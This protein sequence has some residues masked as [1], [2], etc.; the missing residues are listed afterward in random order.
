MRLGVT[1]Q[2][3]HKI[4]AFSRGR[5]LVEPS[6]S[7]SLLPMT[8]VNKA[9]TCND[10]NTHKPVKSSRK[11]TT[12]DACEEACVPKVA[13]DSI[14]LEMTS[15][16]STQGGIPRMVNEPTTDQHHGQSEL[17]VLSPPTAITTNPPRLPIVTWKQL[18]K[19]THEPSEEHSLFS[20]MS[21]SPLPREEARSP[22]QENVSGYDMT[23]FSNW[24]FF[25]LSNAL[26]M[27][28]P[29]GLTGEFMLTLAP[30]GNHADAPIYLDPRKL[31]FLFE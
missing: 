8:P 11:T 4:D 27:M 14:H 24:Q 17:A 13:V 5:S 23:D 3:S 1:L 30:I 21:T 2:S 12:P 7:G 10:F 22:D 25:P 28:I 16:L 29:S 31:G 18:Q 20:S 15:N 6:I 26:N 19:A 9:M